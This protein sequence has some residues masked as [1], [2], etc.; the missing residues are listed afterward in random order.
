MTNTLTNIVNMLNT[1]P[2]YIGKGIMELLVLVV[3]GIIVGWITSTVFARKSEIMAVEGSVLKHKLDIFEELSKRLEL[4]RQQDLLPSDHTSA[5]VAMLKQNGYDIDVCAP[6]T[7]F[8]IFEDPKKLSETI[9]ELDKYIAAHRIYFDSEV[10]KATMIFQNYI[11]GIRR[12]LVLYEEQMINAGLSLDNKNVYAVE[13]SLCISLCIILDED[14]SR[15]VDIL[16]EKLRVSINSLDFKHQAEIPHDMDFFSED[17][18]IMG[19][20]KDTI[21]LQDREKIKALIAS[22][23]ALGLCATK[24]KR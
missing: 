21:F 9:L 14:L 3:G 22:Y 6:L 23:T 17:G 2:D 18:P 7:V 20:L 19:A 4:L 5:I 10:T 11:I 16:L 1:L 13:K 15:Q 24:A 12:L 8:Q